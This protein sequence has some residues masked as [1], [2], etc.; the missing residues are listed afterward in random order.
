MATGPDDAIGM[1]SSGRVLSSRRYVH[2]DTILRYLATTILRPQG[3]DPAV[4]PPARIT[5]TGTPSCGTPS[6]EDHVYRDT[7]LRYTLRRRSRPQCHHPAVHSPARI[8][9][10]G[11]QSCGTP[12]GEDHV[13]RDTILRYTRRRVSWRSRSIGWQ[14][15]VPVR[16]RR[17]GCWSRGPTSLLR[18]P[19][20]A[21]EDHVHRDTI[22]RYTLRRGSRP[23]GHHPA[24]HP[25]AR[26]LAQQVHRVADR[27][28]GQK[29]PTWVL[30]ARSANYLISN[31]SNH[32]VFSKE[33]RR[34]MAGFCRTHA[35]PPR[36]TGVGTYL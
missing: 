22:L 15:V 10:T 25:P 20:P 23:Q 36:M 8:T 7:T 1:P 6:G 29:S 14:I 17:R 18:S 5:S 28:S 4:H 34:G 32:N 12:S 9:S 26:Q 30:V 35:A 31:E 13:H 24:V 19:T 2:R 33:V 11:T 21:G 27:G 3:H 16:S